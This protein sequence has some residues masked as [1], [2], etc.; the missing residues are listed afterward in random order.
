MSH[1]HQRRK[2]RPRRRTDSTQ[3]PPPQGGLR[4]SINAGARVLR[5]DLSSLPQRPCA[6]QR[7]EMS[8]SLGRV[9]I[10]GL[11]LQFEARLLSGGAGSVL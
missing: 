9:S 2:T 3:P 5:R 4:R 7:D 1:P 8:R 6:T 11:H 10:E